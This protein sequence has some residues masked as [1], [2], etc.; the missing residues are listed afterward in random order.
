MTA[1]LKAGATPIAGRTITF[2]AKGN[3]AGSAVTDASG[4]ATLPSGSL[5]GVSGGLWYAGEV[6]VWGGD[7]VYA[8]A[9]AS[10]QLTATTSSVVTFGNA[11]TI[12]PVDHVTALAAGYSRLMALTDTGLVSGWGTTPWTPGS[13]GAT[14]VPSGLSGVT[15]ISTSKVN[16]D[17]TVARKNDGSVAVW[18]D[19]GVAQCSGCTFN[20]VSASLGAIILM[21]VD[22]TGKVT[23]WGNAQEDLNH[24]LTVPS[25]AQSGVTTVA[26][27]TSHAVALKS[28]GTVITW[29]CSTCG[30]TP[31][32]GLTSVVAVA[33]GTDGSSLALRQDGTL[34]RW[35][36]SLGST[37]PAVVT[38]KRFTAIDF[39][40]TNVA[41]ALADD[42]SLYSLTT[43]GNVIG[44][45]GPAPLGL[46]AGYN[47]A[48]VRV[49][50]RL[51]VTG[52]VSPVS[53]RVGETKAFTATFVSGDAPV[54]GV[55]VTFTLNGAAL[56]TATTN[57]SGIA[58]L[59]APIPALSGGTYPTG[60]SATVA[61]DA[62]WQ[63]QPG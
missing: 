56:G 45:A 12:P 5:S 47:W 58:S 10:A 29:G 46:S 41:Y 22:A 3:P 35:G 57:S 49:P 37:L 2:T 51:A 36:G 42:G 15:A 44:S 24:L 1:T 28:D 33:A 14:L 23:A 38:G 31:P 55:P 43:G 4:V 13:L 21:G 62:T 59:T 11:P 6:A 52:T 20:A 53:G 8:A 16:R 48:A 19:L 40:G 39:A 32:S 30:I 9:S 50:T 60:L 27:G 7:L 18:N 25:T 17:T 26:I 63:D 61:T 34:A 54:T